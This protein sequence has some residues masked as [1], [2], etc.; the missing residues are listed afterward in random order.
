MFW[1]YF[2]IMQLCAHFTFETDPIVEQ[3]K[4]KTTNLFFGNKNTL[5][6]NENDH[7]KGNVDD[8]WILK[9]TI[10]IIQ[11][12]VLYSFIIIFDLLGEK[13]F[14]VKSLNSLNPWA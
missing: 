8:F 9:F 3:S 4:Q 10:I 1:L 7:R 6:L 13:A 12:T 11:N 5:D 14:P 2:D